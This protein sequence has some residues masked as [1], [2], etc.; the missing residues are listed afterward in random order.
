MSEEKNLDFALEILTSKMKQ[1][2]MEKSEQ[3]YFGWDDPK[4]M[5]NFIDGLYIHLGKAIKVKGSP[6]QEEVE[7]AWI[8]V[9]NFVMMIFY[10]NLEH[11]SKHNE[12]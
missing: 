12:T 8:D 6:Y 4:N 1:K 9:A 7:Q 11:E 10:A 2:M 5:Q 3:G